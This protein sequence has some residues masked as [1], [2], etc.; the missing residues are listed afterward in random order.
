MSNHYNYETRFSRRYFIAELAKR[1][2]DTEKLKA[3]GIDLDVIFDEANVNVKNDVGESVFFNGA[4]VDRIQQ[5][6]FDRIGEN[7]IY[8]DIGQSLRDITDPQ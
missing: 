3:S 2:F 1:G 5:A 6:L 7:K 4:E 8:F